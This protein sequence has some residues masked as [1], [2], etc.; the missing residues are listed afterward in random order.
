MQEKK[1]SLMDFQGNPNIGI[2]MFANNKFC[3]LGQNINEAKKKEIEKTLGVSVYKISILSTQLIGIFITG[4]DE[5]LLIPQITQEEYLEI[6]NIAK[7]YDVKIITLKSKLNTLGN[8]ICISDRE[9]L[10]NSDYDKEVI[11]NIKKETAYKVTTIK[12][13]KFN[14]IGSTTKFLN[15]KFFL[16]QEYDQNEIKKINKKKIGGIGTI[17]HGSQY[18]ASGVIG[19]NNG[20]IIGKTSTSVEIQNIIENLN[21]I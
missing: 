2:Y 21:Y 6:K 9:I 15:G 4:N 12:S 10:I 20:I 1:V 8:N 17:N 11:D 7:K 16:S 19:N 14:S 13:K 18:I 3:L 5:F